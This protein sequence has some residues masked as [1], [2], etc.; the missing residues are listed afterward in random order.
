MLIWRDFGKDYE[1][2]KAETIPSHRYTNHGRLSRYAWCLIRR[3]ADEPSKIII[4]YVIVISRILDKDAWA[5]VEI[6]KMLFARPDIQ[7]FMEGITRHE[8]AVLHHKVINSS[9]F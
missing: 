4:Q 6:E 2:G 3:K 9:R 8:A 5:A 1:P 7:A